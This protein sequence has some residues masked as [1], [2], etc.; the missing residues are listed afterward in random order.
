MSG[1]IG[2]ENHVLIGALKY[3]FILNNALNL[4]Y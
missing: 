1:V 4:S 3:D 2:Q